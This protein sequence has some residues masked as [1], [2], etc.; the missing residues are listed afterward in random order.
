MKKIFWY[1]F[2][3]LILNWLLINNLMAS[4][5][6]ILSQKDTK[7]KINK[8]L[9]LYDKFI[10]SNPH[11]EELRD[12]AKFTISIEKVSSYFITEIDN[13]SD[14]MVVAE[15]YLELKNIFPSAF[16]LQDNQLKIK[17]ETKYSEVSYNEQLLWL[18]IFALAIVGI[19]ALFSSS[20]QIRKILI[21]HKLMQNKQKKIESFLANIGE[22]IYSLSKENIGYNG[23][24]SKE[25][26]KSPA[27][28]MIEK[29]LF[30]TTRVMIHFLRIKAKRIKIIQE[31]FNLNNVLN[32]IL[33]LL[34]HRFEGSN[35]ELIFDI[36]NDVPKKIIGDPLHLSEVLTEILQNALEYT[37]RGEVKL[38]ISLHLKNTLKF[39]VTDTGLGISDNQLERLFI[40]TYTSNNEY[41]GLGLFVAKELTVLMGG[42]L[43]II[44]S[45]KSGTT[46]DAIIPFGAFKSIPKDY[47]L[48]ANISG[49][50][51]VLIYEHN[52]S[53]AISIKKMFQYFDFKVDIVSPQKFNSDSINLASYDILLLDINKLDK[54]HITNIRNI[55]K[56]SELKVVHLS[57]IFSIKRF[58]AHD[59]IDDWIEKPIHQERIYEL[60]I[61]LF[62][63]SQLEKDKLLNNKL[64]V[65]T[66]DN[67]VEID[68][69]ST[70]NFINFKGRNILIVEDNVI[71]Q[72]VMYSIL[73]KVGINITIANH[74]EEALEYLDKDNKYDLILMDISM[75]I[76]D[77][78]ETI[79]KIRNQ[80]KFDNIPIIALTSLAL[81]NDI[82]KIFRVGTNGYLRKPLKIGYLYSTLQEFLGEQDTAVPIKRVV[83]KVKEYSGRDGLDVEKGIRL[84][85]GSEELYKEVL[86]E[87]LSAYED[88]GTSLALWV[89]EGRY[90]H[91]KRL[92]L[93]MKG[94]TGS[95]GAYKM[96]ELVDTMHK[97]FLY[98]NVH[99][100]PKF[101]ESYNEELQSLVETIKEYMREE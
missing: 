45:D 54:T 100:I 57:N 43:K 89:N 5:S 51:K 63:S 70:N 15:L 86:D 41:K 88:S 81:D 53:S 37:E 19:L 18:A 48:S 64:K 13:I 16:I 49:D 32:G 21:R 10:K 74:G 96:F 61:S 99:L 11:L 33:G 67:L 65:I 7:E 1:F 3:T 20:L 2:T 80:A 66:P 91:V 68:N 24:S 22:N 35:I 42:E 77:G 93:D 52:E 87:F 17:Y 26:E 27:K 98:N 46:F 78:Y 75:P 40:P 59:Y 34:G 84:S 79:T 4:D 82:N 50:K 31:E 47:E 25:I 28:A 29:K 39:E 12:R 97:Q 36:D 62:N 60:I 90:E 95:I 71:D 101:V 76:M 73:T 23:D 44:K 8:D 9:K 14:Q 83:S 58:I 94:L 85:G 30:S 69:I 6:I 55:R 72:K 92:C 56:N 38:S